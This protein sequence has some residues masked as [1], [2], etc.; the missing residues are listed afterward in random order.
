MSNQL[1]LWQIPQESPDDILEHYSRESDGIS[2]STEFYRPSPPKGDGTWEMSTAPMARWV[3]TTIQGYT[4]EPIVLHGYYSQ[5][6]HAG[7]HNIREHFLFE[8]GLEPGMSQDIL[9]QLKEND[10]RLIHL[11]IDKWGDGTGITTYGFD[12]LAGD[13]NS[14]SHVNLRDFVVLARNWDA[15]DCCACEGAELTGNGQLGFDDLLELAD[16]WLS[17][18]EL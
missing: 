3:Q 7:H 9:D 11:I 13:F 15:I 1:H 6:Y 8:P 17:E 10:I 14:D 16:N 2:I 12:F 5:T 4:A 18:T